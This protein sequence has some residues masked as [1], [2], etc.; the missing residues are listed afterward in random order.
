MIGPAI[1]TAIHQG[2]QLGMVAALSGMGLGLSWGDAWLVSSLYGL[3]TTVGILVVVVPG[4]IVVREGVFVALAAD[5]LGGDQALAFAALV[6]LLLAG[7]DLWSAF[8]AGA[9]RW[10]EERTSLSE[11]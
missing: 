3:A 1:L 8:A 4:G 5:V 6:R 11:R 2:A 7:F 9:L 10:A